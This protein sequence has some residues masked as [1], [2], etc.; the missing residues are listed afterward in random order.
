MTAVTSDS[1]QY[2]KQ[3]SLSGVFGIQGEWLTG[4]IL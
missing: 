3:L 4:G 2:R 1:E